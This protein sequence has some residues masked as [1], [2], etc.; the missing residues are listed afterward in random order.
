MVLALGFFVQSGALK[1]KAA[2]NK[3]DYSIKEN[4]LYY[5]NKKIKKLPAVKNEMMENWGISACYGSRLFLSKLNNQNN[6]DKKS[7]VTYSYD[8][9][10]KKL[11]KLKS[12]CDIIDICGKY[13][14]ASSY[15]E[16][17]FELSS[18]SVQDHIFRTEKIKKLGDEVRG[19]VFDKKKL[20][21]SIYP[22]ISRKQGT[23]CRCNPDGSGYKEIKIFSKQ[24]E[25][26]SVV[27]T[28]VN[29]KYC[30]VWI[31]GY[32]YR[33]TIATGKMKKLKS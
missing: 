30:E 24:E 27:I 26:G 8:T 4:V 9:K 28:P 18:N 10:T 11:K 12:G 31:D 25:Y 13:V 23:L 33:Y 22:D 32:N 1:V 7:A 16:D 19:A 20:Y 21:Y 29:S 3:D 2:V 17:F 5:K 6:E 15:V 14:A